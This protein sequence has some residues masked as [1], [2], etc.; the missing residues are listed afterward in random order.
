[1]LGLIVVR[2]NYLALETFGDRPAGRRGHPATPPKSWRATEPK[3][4]P[5][6]KKFKRVKWPAGGLPQGLP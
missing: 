2:E 3:K 1:M 4:I 6:K 5:K